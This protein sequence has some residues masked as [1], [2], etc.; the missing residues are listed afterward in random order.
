[1]ATRPG[2]RSRRRPTRDPSVTVTA[3]ARRQSSPATFTVNDPHT[4]YVGGSRTRRRSA[5]GAIFAQ[6]GLHLLRRHVPGQGRIARP[7][8]CKLLETVNLTITAGD[9]T[10]SKVSGNV[11]DERGHPQRDRADLDRRPEG[12]HGQ[13]LPRRRARVVARGRFSGLTGPPKPS[14]GNFTIPSTALTWT[15]SC[16]AGH[17]QRRHGRH[18]VVGHVFTTGTTDVPVCSVTTDEP[19]RRRDQRWR[20]RGRR[21]LCPWPSPPTRRPAAYTGTIR[22]RSRELIESSRTSDG[23]H[24]SRAGG[25]HRR[26]TAPSAVT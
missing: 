22:S 12:R 14:S 23:C 18:R 10:M 5:A 3:D 8:N 19:R 9:L 26:S 20:H 1:M 17:Q 15:P 16:V 6:R 2:R 13:G 11:T 21:R 24:R 7:G 4:A 25:T